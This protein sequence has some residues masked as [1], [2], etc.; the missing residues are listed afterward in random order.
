MSGIWDGV[1]FTV[2][3]FIVQRLKPHHQKQQTFVGLCPSRHYGQ[4]GELLDDRLRHPLLCRIHGEA[5]QWTLLPDFSFTLKWHKSTA[6]V[7]GVETKEQLSVKAPSIQREREF[8]PPESEEL[9][10]RKCP[11]VRRSVQ[12][13]PGELQNSS[14]GRLVTKRSVSRLSPNTSVLF[15]SIKQA[16]GKT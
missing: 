15:N 9:K 6:S 12:S 16:F 13:C 7:P 3:T 10:I 11:H 1:P 2:L 5:L 8:F 4:S 14:A